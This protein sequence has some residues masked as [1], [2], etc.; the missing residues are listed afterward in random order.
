MFDQTEL[1]NFKRNAD[2]YVAGQP[3]QPANPQKKAPGG[4][5]GLLLNALPIVG[6]AVGTVAGGAAGTILPGA[7]N[8][9]G[10]IGGGAVGSGLGEFL[11]QKLSGEAENGIDR[12]NIVQ[13]GLFGA[14]PGVGKGVRA[15]R[16]ARGAKG[17]IEVAEG[18]P[19]RGVK[20]PQTT[21]AAMQARKGISSRVQSGAQQMSQ[22]GMG[23][24]VGQSA[25]R[26]K[27]L[28]PDKADELSEF[29]TNRSQQYGGIRAGKPINQ[30]KDA[31][32]VHNNV[33]KS[34]DDTLN[35]IDRP[36]QAGEPQGILA[37]ALAKVGD[38]PAI[39]STTKTVEKF[40]TKIEK[41]K[42]LKELEAIRREADD[43][44]YTSTGAGKTS[45]AAQSHAVRDAI[46]E[47]ITPLSDD[48][49]AIKGDYALSRDALEATSK[50]NKNAK[51]FKLPFVDVEIGKQTI[52]GAKNKVA[53]KIAGSGSTPPPIAPVS[54]MPSFR[55]FMG[56]AAKATIPQAGYRA[57]G[58]ALFGTPFVNSE[59]SKTQEQQQ[60]TAPALTNTE[61]EAL[62][63]ATQGQT[64]SSV[65]SDPT[66]VE[67][68]YLQALASGDTETASALIKGFELFGGGKGEKPLSAEASKVIANANSGLTSLSQ[69][70]SV[71]DQQGGVS[72]ATLVPGRGMFGGLGANV[73][74][75]AEYDTAAKN[76]TD[77]I[78]RLRTGAALTNEEAAFYQGQVP[79]AFDSPRVRQQKIQTFRDLFESV[80]NRTG[81][82]GTDIQAAVGA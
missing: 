80:A 66:R 55:P 70:E 39:T 49:K 10:A 67:Q 78:T 17:A 25:G 19:A 68:A 26:G 54:G 28:T 20:A 22:E 61:S 6:G 30:A 63:G 3:K 79:Q 82:A 69:L 64:S 60:P 33:I 45:A 9:A 46:D 14:L 42:S 75:T 58:A 47:F 57:G 29:I 12:G 2:A 5:R 41:A 23:L 16:A 76:L 13:E 48:Y 4:L 15:F 24:T 32:V 31:Q 74:G 51:G 53:S 50:A 27:V 8:V 40:K 72:K 71:I 65:F 11:R 52:S 7:G 34:L 36:L 44:A 62:R 59:P 35:Q 1:D 56:Q 18:L 21:E 38:N 81:S 77:V 43:L 37:N 73:L